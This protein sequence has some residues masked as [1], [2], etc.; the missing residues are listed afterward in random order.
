M[1][2]VGRKCILLSEHSDVASSA[3]LPPSIA[4]ATPL[5]S[6]DTSEDQVNTFNGADIVEADAN[7]DANVLD[8]RLI[9]R[10]EDDGISDIKED[11][12]VS[13]L[14][15]FD[16]LSHLPP[17]CSDWLTHWITA[18]LRI[19]SI[20]SG[21]AS[22]RCVSESLID[23]FSTSLGTSIRM[24]HTCTFEIAKHARDVIG[25][26]SEC[27]LFGDLLSLIPSRLRT[28]IDAKERTFGELQKSIIFDRAQ[29]LSTSHCY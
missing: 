6:K 4:H 2:E 29:L 11:V 3:A 14:P 27:S 22:E 10:Y 24:H 23:C 1:L 7:L 13:I 16:W 9:P 8:E 12:H 21:I 25:L 17:P 15:Q 20:F 28:W 19:S 26:T 5:L 18:G